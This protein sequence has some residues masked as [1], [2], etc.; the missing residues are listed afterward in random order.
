MRLLAILTFVCSRC[1]NTSAHRLE[2]RVRKFTL[3]FIPLFPI[4]RRR[5]FGTCTYCGLVTE[6][7][8]PTRDRLLAD[9]RG[10][11]AGGQAL[12]DPAPGQIQRF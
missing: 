1:G 2:E 7:D 11:A 8:D 3:F 12:G 5:T 4:G 10:T 6:V 9:A